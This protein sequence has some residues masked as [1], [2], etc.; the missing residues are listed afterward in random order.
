[1]QANEPGRSSAGANMLA[2]SPSRSPAASRA[3][4]PTPSGKLRP[5]LLVDQTKSASPS[6]SHSRPSSVKAG[7]KPAVTSSGNLA[8]AAQTLSTGP[9]SIADRSSQASEQWTN[10]GDAEGALVRRTYAYFDKE[11]INDDGF[12]EGQE[13]TRH[14][15]NQLPWDARPAA[16]PRPTSEK[17]GE[18]S[19]WKSA[20]EEGKLHLAPADTAAK[21][22][23]NGSSAISAQLS[24]G[25]DARRA[26]TPRASVSTPGL[27]EREIRT[28]DSSMQAS[29][30]DPELG[31]LLGQIDRCALSAAHVSTAKS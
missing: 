11:G 27:T 13:F 8:P 12:V 22:R 24:A 2:A 14:R 18:G 21:H 20:M 30:V 31:E 1:M 7:E 23:S 25:D 6:H 26:G 28:Q 15:T 29:G 19:M 3:P 10:P 17:L 16:S 9:K 4:S 5:L